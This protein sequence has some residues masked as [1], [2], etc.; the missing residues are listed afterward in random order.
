M[1]VTSLYTRQ[2]KKYAFLI[3]KFFTPPL[4]MRGQQGDLYFREEEFRAAPVSEKLCLHSSV[5]SKYIIIVT[6]FSASATP[7]DLTLL[8]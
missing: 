5:P 3:Y 1:L 7:A 2:K 8:R 6:I 4:R